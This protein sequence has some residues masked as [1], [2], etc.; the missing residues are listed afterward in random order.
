MLKFTQRILCTSYSQAF[1]Q[2]FRAYTKPAFPLGKV[3]AKSLAQ[4]STCVLFIQGKVLKRVAQ[5]LLKHF[6][7]YGPKISYFHFL[8]LLS[9]M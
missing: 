3:S 8:P 9:D 2:S 5:S 7:S 6:F 1:S 4:I